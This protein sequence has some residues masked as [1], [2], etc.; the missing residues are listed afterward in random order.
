MKWWKVAI[1]NFKRTKRRISKTAPKL[2]LL[3]QKWE[4]ANLVW[5]CLSENP[6]AASAFPLQKMSCFPRGAVVKLKNESSIG[7]NV[8]C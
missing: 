1:L 3:W 5:N 7:K 4:G 2:K 8:G 6:R